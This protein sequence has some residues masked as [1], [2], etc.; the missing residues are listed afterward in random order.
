MKK[1]LFNFHF[2]VCVWFS[3]M[4]CLFA[5]SD[6]MPIFLSSVLLSGVLWFTF[7]MRTQNMSSD[8]IAK[9]FGV[10]GNKFLDCSEE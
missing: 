6:N 10:K 5:A 3:F 1:F 2:G 8:Q 7:W 9:S 4:S